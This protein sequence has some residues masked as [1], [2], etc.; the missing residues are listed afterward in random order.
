M[1]EERNDAARVTPPMRRFSTTQIALIAA[2]ILIAAFAVWTFASTRRSNPDRLPDGN[3]VAATKLADP[4]RRCASQGTYDQIKRELFRR[5]AGL[6]GSDQAAFDKLAAYAVVR[7]DRPLLDSEDEGTGAV[8]CSGALTLDLPPGVAVIGGRRT[9]NADIGYTLQRSADGNGDVL[10]LTRAD[11]IITPLATLARVGRAANDTPTPAPAD[12]LAPLSSSASAFPPPSVPVRPTP[13][14]PP[15]EMAPP[16]SASRPSFNCANART[17]GEIA[18][19]RDDR[20]GA[21][22]R[23]MAAQYVDALRDA[24]PATRAM[25]QRSRDRFLGY[26]DQCPSSDCIADTYRGRMR[27]I[28]DISSGR[29]R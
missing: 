9:L 15:P 25:L 17:R 4:A 12:P 29:L 28:R 13:P 8:A 1:I 3:S 21:L 2:G 10:K 5:A 6:R 14:P 27:E 19:C 26:R 23:Q 11:A 24:D 7:I 16:Q 18:V 20:L 22:D